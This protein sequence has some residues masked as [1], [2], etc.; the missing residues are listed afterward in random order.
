M[1]SRTRFSRTTQPTPS[2]LKRGGCLYLRPGAWLWSHAWTPGSTSTRARD[3]RRGT[4]WLPRDR[5]EE[6]NRVREGDE[7]Q[8]SSADGGGGERG[9]RFV[10]GA[11]EH[12]VELPL[13]APG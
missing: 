13:R 5:W 1:R 2:H 6:T 11:D 7:H 10:Y 9:R 8:F 4:G 3:T 12:D